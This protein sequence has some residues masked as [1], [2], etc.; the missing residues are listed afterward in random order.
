MLEGNQF[1]RQHAILVPLASN[2]P[3]TL[4]AATSQLMRTE[5]SNCAIAPIAL[6]LLLFHPES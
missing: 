3:I 6:D 1:R 4:S 5:I 2:R